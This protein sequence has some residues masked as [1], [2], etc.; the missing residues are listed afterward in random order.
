[1]IANL[2]NYLIKGLFLFAFLYVFKIVIYLSV[3]SFLPVIVTLKSIIKENM[4]RF[5]KG[6]IFKFFIVLRSSSVNVFGD[7]FTIVVIQNAR[8]EFDTDAW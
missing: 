3:G 7:K 2:N 4:I 8:T 1:M 6:N 5:F